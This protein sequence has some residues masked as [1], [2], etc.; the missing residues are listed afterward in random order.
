LANIKL[1][2]GTSLGC[3]VS[4]IIILYHASEYIK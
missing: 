4:F 2:E 3:S 1:N